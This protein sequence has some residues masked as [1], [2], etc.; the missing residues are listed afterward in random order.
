VPAAQPEPSTRVTLRRTDAT[1]ISPVGPVVM[2]VGIVMAASAAIPWLVAENDYRALARACSE[3]CPRDANARGDAIRRLD[4]AT[5][6]LLFGGLATA[7]VGTLLLIL[8]RRPAAPERPS[9]VIGASG[10]GIAA[11]VR[12]AF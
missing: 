7:A 4:V 10:D 6:I 12:G 11:S 1:V 2:G 8:V 3:A 9:V 5:D